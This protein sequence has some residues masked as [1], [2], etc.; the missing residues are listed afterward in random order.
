MSK[1]IFLICHIFLFYSCSYS[2][3][4][5]YEDY[6][7]ERQSIGKYDLSE[8]SDV[9]LCRLNDMTSG[10][11]ISKQIRTK[12]SQS[13]IEEIESRK[14]DCEKPFPQQEEKYNANEED[15]D[16]FEWFEELLEGNYFQES[17]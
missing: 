13:V 6:V 9:N 7:K 8:S 1:K 15:S 4:P 14:L 10:R 2:I 11:L 5:Q 12:I 17:G 16:F 3:D